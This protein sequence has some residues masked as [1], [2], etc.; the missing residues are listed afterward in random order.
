MSSDQHTLSEYLQ[1]ELYH[2]LGAYEIVETR[3]AKLAER[4]KLGTAQPQD[5]EPSTSQPDE[6]THNHDA[7]LE[8]TEIVWGYNRDLAY[9]RHAANTDIRHPVPTKLPLSLHTRFE[10]KSTDPGIAEDRSNPWREP[11]ACAWVLKFYDAAISVLRATPRAGGQEREPSIDEI[12][13]GNLIS[14][15][16]GSFNTSSDASRPTRGKRQEDRRTRYEERRDHAARDLAGDS[17]ESPPDAVATDALGDRPSDGHVDFLRRITSDNLST[18]PG[19]LPLFVIKAQA[20]AH[21]SM[22]GVEAWQSLRLGEHAELTEKDQRWLMQELDR[23]IAL[24][25]FA[26]CVSRS[27]PWI[28]AESEQECR[29]VFE[30]LDEAWR[31]VRP[32]RCMWIACQVS[33]LALHRRAYAR[34]LKDDQVQAYNDYHKLQ[35]LIREADRRVRSAPIHVEGALEFLAGLD[36]QAHHHIGELYRGQHAHQPALKHFRAASH[37]LELLEKEDKLKDVLTNSRWHVQLQVSHGKASYEIGRHK[38]SLCWHLRGWKAFLELL[39]ARTHTEASTEEIDGAIGWLE[40]VRYE[41]ELRKPELQTHIKPVVAQLNRITVPGRFGV[42]AADILLRLGH[43]LFV[44][45]LDSG[46]DLQSDVN[47]NP[48]EALEQARETVEEMLAFN[49]LRKAAICDP[50]STLVGADLLKARLRVRER[51]ADEIPPA[52]DGMLEPKTLGPVPTQWPGGGENY[53]R[54]ARVTEYLMLRAMRGEPASPRPR[55]STP[56]A[57][58]AEIA[59]HLLLNFLTHTDSINVRKSQ[60]HRFLTQTSE[61]AQPPCENHGAA[62]EFVCMR[63]YSSAF[64][65]LPRPSA[66]RAL[67][68]GYFVRLH[69]PA[70]GATEREKPFGIVIDPGVDFVENLYRTGHSLEDVQMIIVTHDHVDHVGALDPLLS[71]LYTGSELRKRQQDADPQERELP[72]KVLVNKSVYSRYAYIDEPRRKRKEPTTFLR[73]ERLKQV[74]AS[75]LIEGF[76]SEF[77]IM[78]MTTRSADGAGHRDLGGAPSHGLYFSTEAGGPSLAITGDTPRPPRRG[79]R[80]YENWREEWLPALRADVL[81][82]HLSSV[83]LT[84]LRKLA[85]LEATDNAR[86][87]TEQ[88]DQIRA[89]ARQ[90]IVDLRGRR[91]PA[92]VRGLRGLRDGA[93]DLAAGLA[94]SR[95]PRMTPDE[96]LAVAR[97]L[98]VASETLDS[99]LIAAAVEDGSPHDLRSKELIQDARSLAGAAKDLPA[100]FIEL[101]RILGHLDRPDRHLKG[102]LTFAMWLR[103]RSPAS[104]TADLVG[105]VP[106]LWEPPKDHSYLSGIAD[107]ARDYRQARGE[108]RPGL[109]IIGELSDELGTMRGQVAARLNETILKPPARGGAGPPR[110][111]ARFYAL[112]AD[113]GLR[114]FVVPDEHGGQVPAA[115]TK[116]R[117][118][119]LCTTCN[120]DTDRVSKERFHQAPLIQEVCVKGENEGIFYNCQEHDP[121]TQEEPTFLEQL[122]RFD[123]FGR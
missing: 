8:L 22:H 76:P 38:E 2:V 5:E 32:T 87:M 117:A 112:T 82:A 93:H 53:E 90:L 101:K 34:T 73:L 4:L 94:A 51:L 33:L 86:S 29:K 115:D 85:S 69:R 118:R 74:R 13:A 110:T 99:A 54:I 120:L 47:L 46:L 1:C 104:A 71:L 9:F 44:L 109:F 59:R 102:R 116:R 39:A 37:S 20:E 77:E 63:R 108:R 67:G 64:P 119:V 100:E 107:W 89:K 18:G 81:I 27:A 23:C 61:A 55:P 95:M 58:N 24:D 83:P 17:P 68:G 26:Y 40:K 96:L 49:C 62:I 7:L 43:L 97:K 65:L 14:R 48:D 92:L 66:F 80:E 121:S 84:E 57:E 105:P 25:T 72:L 35:R 31:N 12:F 3:L 88:A 79:A 45:N 70:N 78:P 6:Q 56:E 75:E 36:A 15:R 106:E 98:E 103:G 60:V 19:S 42:L 122:E 41:P 113:I 123:I 21:L 28:F 50:N 111:A 16:D 52:Y 11:Q 10:L 91:L 114:M 30:D